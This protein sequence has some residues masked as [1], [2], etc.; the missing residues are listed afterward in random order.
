MTSLVNPE[1]TQYSKNPAKWSE[2]STYNINQFIYLLLKSMFATDTL[3]F[4]AIIRQI[5]LLQRFINN[6]RKQ[7]HL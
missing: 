3:F 2:N 5:D 1:T 7:L 4:M 6:L